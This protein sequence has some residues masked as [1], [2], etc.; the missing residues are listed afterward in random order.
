MIQGSASRE[1]NAKANGNRQEEDNHTTSGVGA[2]E[3]VLT[4]YAPCSDAGHD[5]GEGEERAT[6]VGCAVEGGGHC[7]EKPIY[8]KAAG[9]RFCR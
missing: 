3:H 7:G 1:D 4:P 5:G 2:G 9:G 6:L 8:T